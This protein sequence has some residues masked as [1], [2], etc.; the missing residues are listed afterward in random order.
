MIIS[1]LIS[2]LSYVVIVMSIVVFVVVI[3]MMMKF[4]L[5]TLQFVFVVCGFVIFLSSSSSCHWTGATN[6]CLKLCTVECS[7]TF[8]FRVM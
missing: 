8:H 1:S 6:Y 2:Y 5:C 7:V 3:D 4:R